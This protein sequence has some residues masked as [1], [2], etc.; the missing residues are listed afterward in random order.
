M[1]R[2]LEIIE[3]QGTVT[4]LKAFIIPNL[5]DR[6]TTYTDRD[7]KQR[8]KITDLENKLVAIERI[9]RINASYR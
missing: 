4:Y 2:L 5:K 8:K 7:V 6:L 1:H 9:A 3:L